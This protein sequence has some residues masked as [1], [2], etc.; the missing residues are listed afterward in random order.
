MR[1]DIL[2]SRSWARPLP[3]VPVGGP[4]AVPP[5][6]SLPSTISEVIVLP[7]LAEVMASLAV[8]LVRLDG[9]AVTALPLSV[10]PGAPWMVTTL[11]VAVAE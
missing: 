1:A 7:L 11:S 4:T 10:V 6:S 3:L 2:E 9:V 5:S 8:A